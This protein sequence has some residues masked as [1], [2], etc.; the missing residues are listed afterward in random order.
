MNNIVLENKN[1]LL[2]LSEDGYALSLLHKQS[3]RE[4]LSG[5]R[6]PFMVL[7]EERPFDNNI[8]LA[9]LCKRTAFAAKSLRL[10]G[11][12]LICGFELINSRVAVKVKVTDNY[13]GFEFD[14]LLSGD[15]HGLAM[16]FPPVSELRFLQLSVKKTE[17]YG[18]WLGVLWD[19]EVS[20]NVMAVDPLTRVEPKPEKE[21]CIIS[22]D[23]LGG[24]K[25]E[26]AKAAL[27]VSSQDEFLNVVDR[28]EEDYS[29][30]RGVKN[31][32]GDKINRSCYWTSNI[33]PKNVDTHIA[34]AKKAGF[35]LMLIYY[36]AMFERG[37]FYDTTNGFEYSADYPNGREDLEQM[38]EKIKA[39][40]I[41]AG[42]H[43]LH[44]HIGFATD[45]ITPVADHR[46]RLKEYFTLSSPLSED[47]TVLYVEQS[48][49]FAPKHEKCKILRFGGELIKYESVSTEWPYCFIG[50]ERG[51]LGTQ[52]TTHY[53]GEIGG[54]LDVSEYCATSAYIDQRTSLQD[55]IADK[56][57]EV[58]N[59]GFEF[60]Y[61][62]GSEGADEP[63]DIYIPYA[64]YRVYKKLKPEPLFCEGAAKAHFSWHMLSGGNAFDV[65]GTKIFKQMTDLHPAAE[66][67]RMQKDF[68]RINFGW[69]AFRDDT[70]PDTIEYGTSRAAGFDCPG[71]LMENQTV[72]QN[73]KRIDDIFEVVRRWE[74]VREHGLLSD[75]Q[76]ADLRVLG[77]EH[78]LII[79]E[80]GEYELCSCRQIRDDQISAFLIERGGKTTVSYWHKTG[81]AKMRLPIEAKSITCFDDFSLEHYAPESSNGK[82]ELLVEGKRYFETSLSPEEVEKAF[83]SAEIL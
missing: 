67:A 24:I 53:K 65:F 10:E 68:T 29:L 6:V 48:P 15:S 39:E 23:A 27:I 75:E 43:I 81:G 35:S 20:V 11:D 5:D 36:S 17:N 31:R 69:W 22:A 38:L 71:T 73:H 64:Q 30:P 44:T 55:E 41:T 32:R 61:F 34:C 52:R 62:D 14:E 2:I 45:Y 70:Q 46:L 13:M 66:A 80:Q 78:T 57:A 54:V 3:G 79:N 56:L 4:L 49:K 72:F 26:G 76:K 7:T 74:H 21:S 8:K 25:L 1:F 12:R 42:L 60:I 28:V 83:L 19:S 77:S 63:Y 50:C 58:Y 18:E 33:T 59:S 9:H 47:D 51:A 37:N 40:G 16:D 82:A